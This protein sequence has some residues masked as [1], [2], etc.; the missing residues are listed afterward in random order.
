MM[1]SALSS[2]FCCREFGGDLLCL[3]VERL[4]RRQKLVDHGCTG[5]F[6]R[7]RMKGRLRVVFHRE[8]LADNGNYL[9]AAF[10]MLSNHNQ[11][12]QA[13]RLRFSVVLPLVAS[14]LPV[15]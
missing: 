11:S 12:M 10:R 4:H 13:G 6:R 7:S 2:A 9:A 14:G 1:Q 15:L 3:P 5:A 8:L